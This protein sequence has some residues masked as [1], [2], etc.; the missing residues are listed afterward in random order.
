MKRLPLSITA[1]ALAGLAT[2]GFAIAPEKGAVL[3]TDA[4]AISQALAADGYEITRYLESHNIETRP[5][6]AGN[7]L[8][9]PAYKGIKC[10]KIGDLSVSDRIMSSAFFI[11]V[12]PGLDE[13]RLRYVANVFDS[14]IKTH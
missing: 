13:H 4:T 1:L 9:Q 10:R 6:F 11:G 5:L 7:I 8:K 14:F 3:G 2:A 12:Y